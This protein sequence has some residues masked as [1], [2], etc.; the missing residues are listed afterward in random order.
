MS[1]LMAKLK[2]SNTIKGSSVLSQSKFF[3][4]EFYSSGIP[5]LDIALSARVKGGG[6]SRGSILIA[7]DSKTFKTLFML[8]LAKNYLEAVPDSIFI[9]Y[10][11]EF[12][13]NTG[14]MESVGIDPERVMHKPIH[15]IEQLKHD[16]TQT[17]DDL[18]EKDNVI[19]GIDSLGQIAS[20]KEIEDAIDGKSVA[21]MTR[22]KALNSFWRIVN[23]YLN[24]KKIPM[25]AIGRSYDSQD[26]YPKPVISGGKGMEFTPNNI[27]IIG[28]QQEKDGKDYVG[29]NF[30]VNVH[31]SRLVKEKSKFPIKVTFE[32]GLFKYSGLLEIARTTGHIETGKLGWYNVKGSDKK[33]RK[34]DFE[35]DPSFWEPILEDP[36]FQ[37]QV[38]NMYEL[39]NLKGRPVEIQYDLE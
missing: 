37:E 15:N 3:T 7:G 17:L 27:W 19:I 36:D 6:F 8:I 39:G 4:D 25:I 21:D 29:N 33:L 31:K 22:A 12:G 23:P 9:F 1:D 11:C 20:A 32:D 5:V 24:T 28:K 14:T 18:D 30:I 26:R 16:V 38:K 13:T 10:D 34:A 2:K 35:D